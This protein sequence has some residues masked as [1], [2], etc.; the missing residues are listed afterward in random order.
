FRGTLCT[1]HYL[2]STTRDRMLAA[3]EKVKEVEAL[4]KVLQLQLERITKARETEKQNLGGFLMQG[5][6][7]EMEVAVKT[8]RELVDIKSELGYAGYFRVPKVIDINARVQMPDISQLSE[9]ERASI[10]AFSDQFLEMMQ[11]SEAEQ[12]LAVR[13]DGVFQAANGQD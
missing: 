4:E 11:L 10:K 7:R 5:I 13:E 12:E 6:H 2:D 9:E 8:A 1:E 3:M